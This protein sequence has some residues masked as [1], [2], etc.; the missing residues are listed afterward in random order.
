MTLGV[1]CVWVG[2]LLRWVLWLLWG[3]G[4]GEVRLF[5][6]LLCGCE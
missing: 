4:S 6:G 1:V 2:V 5:G 3:L